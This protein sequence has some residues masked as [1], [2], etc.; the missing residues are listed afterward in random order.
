MNFNYSEEQGLLKESIVRWAQDNYSFDQR[1]VGADSAQGFSKDHWNTFAELGWLSVPFAEEYGGYGGNVDDVAAVMEEFGKALVVEPIF[2]TLIL[3]GGV[4][5][6]SSNQSVKAE[7]IPQ[8]IDGNLIGAVAIYEPHSR[9]DMSNVS[10]SAV[11]QGD[12][13]QISGNKSVVLGGRDAA[14]LIVLARTS[15]EQRDEDGLSLFLVDA[16]SAG[17]TRNSFELMDGQ[18]A[19]DIVLSNASGQ[20]VSELGGGYAVVESAMRT[21]NVALCAEALGIME[22]LNHATVEYT[23]TRKQFGVA[24]SNF[25]ALQHRMVDTFMAF[26]QSKSLLVGALCELTDDATDAKQAEKVV[27]ALRALTAKNGKLIG[28]EAIQIHGGM[29]MTDELAV[30]NYVKRLMMINLMFGNG[31]LFQS[32]FNQVAYA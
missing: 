22:K 25:Q 10:T 4:L 24:I 14:Q 11:A 29:G 15:G 27:N 19:C 12:N 31:D 13:Y 20:L 6:N 2:S 1:R 23:K 21:A 9:F 18:Q 17:V 32:Q 26:E 28:D 16:N 30:G 7:L 5:Q 3:F 8:I